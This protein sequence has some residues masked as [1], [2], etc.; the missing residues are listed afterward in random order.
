MI[1]AGREAPPREAYDPAKHARPVP[2]EAA[3]EGELSG[4]ANLEAPDRLSA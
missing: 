2:E 3:G 1:G 4:G